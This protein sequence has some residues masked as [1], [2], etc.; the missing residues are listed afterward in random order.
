MKTRRG[1]LYSEMV[2]VVLVALADLAPIARCGERTLC[3]EDPAFSPLPTLPSLP[4]GMTPAD[5]A[6]I[7]R[8]GERT[9]CEE[10]PPVDSPL[11]IRSSSQSSLAPGPPLP[12]LPLSISSNASG[13]T[14]D[15]VSTLAPM[16]SKVSNPDLCLHELAFR[17][18]DMLRAPIARVGE[19]EELRWFEASPFVRPP[20]KFE[21]GLKPS[22]I[23]ERSLETD[24]ERAEVAPLLSR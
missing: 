17:S 1:N 15:P 14:I 8:C 6:P 20:R 3:E 23:V 5:L 4:S 9:R 7:A 11:P 12:R 13:L 24:P 21:S 19:R 2:L 18:I 16:P 22:V 10:D